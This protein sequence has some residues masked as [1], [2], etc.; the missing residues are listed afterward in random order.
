MNLINMDVG[1]RLD[2][3]VIWQYYERE[4]SLIK[5]RAQTSEFIQESSPTR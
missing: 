3:I 4:M 1:F 2:R 5:K